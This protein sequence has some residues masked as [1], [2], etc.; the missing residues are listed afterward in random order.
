MGTA[1]DI[2]DLVTQLSDSI[3]DRKVAAELFKIIS[4]TNQ[5]Q[6]EN[7]DLQ[8]E[9]F[10]LQK[11][12]ME[13]NHKFFELKKENQELQQKLNDKNLKTIFHENLL[14]LSDDPNPYCPAC[15]ES[16]NKQIHMVK[17]QYHDIVNNKVIYKPAYKCPKCKY[18][19]KIVNHPKMENS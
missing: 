1:K 11:E 14:W 18:M 13:L 12:S 16:E 2:I 3:Q 10:K 17:S 6:S 5:L 19:A 8:A 9:N 4:L 15:H 7:A